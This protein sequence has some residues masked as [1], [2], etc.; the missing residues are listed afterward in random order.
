[1]GEGDNSGVGRNS[2]GATPSVAKSVKENDAS[3]AM[4]PRPSSTYLEE[5]EIPKVKKKHCY[6][7]WAEYLFRRFCNVFSKSSPC[8]LGQHGSC[9]TVKSN[10]LGNSQKIVYKTFG[11]SGRPTLYILTY[12]LI[13]ALNP[14]K[15]ERGG[16]AVEAGYKAAICPRLK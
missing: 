5:E 3:E 1:M 10:G 6:T 8:L 9:S 12:K 2:N 13:R 16:C 14:K 4:I 7:G 11:T 15:G